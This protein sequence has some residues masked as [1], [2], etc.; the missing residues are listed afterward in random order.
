MLAFICAHRA[1][2]DAPSSPQTSPVDRRTRAVLTQAVITRAL[3]IENPAALAAQLS[4]FPSGLIAPAQRQ[5]ARWWTLWSLFFKGSLTKVGFGTRHPHILYLNPIADVAVIVECAKPKTATTVL[6]RHLCAMPGET[7]GGEA[8][9]KS[10]AWATS[11]DPL[12]AIQAR[13]RARI[14]GFTSIYDSNS[15][16][17][18]EPQLCSQ[19]AQSIAEVRLLDLLLSTEGLS[20]HAFS[21]AVADYVVSKSPKDSNRAAKG[22][23][24][25]DTALAVFSRAPGLSFSAAVRVNKEGWLV[26]LTPKSTGWDQAAVTLKTEAG[27]A[28]L[29]RSATVLSY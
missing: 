1:Q 8:P 19:N 27:G 20:A 24:P 25:S 2:A 3:G 10:P 16:R 15:D 29:V 14:Q 21:K 9:A 4:S 11:D 22:A 7:L 6:C 5:D 23:L 12:V 28:L 26:F 17:A 18:V 13:A